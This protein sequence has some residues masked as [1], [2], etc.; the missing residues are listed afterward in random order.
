MTT[1]KGHG[2]S[3]C[4]CL[5]LC[6]FAGGWRKREEE[7]EAKALLLVEASL[8]LPLCSCICV[9]AGCVWLSQD[10]PK[11]AT[12]RNMSQDRKR[13][14]TREN[15]LE[16]YSYTTEEA[17]KGSNGTLHLLYACVTNL[18]RIRMGNPSKTMVKTSFSV[19]NG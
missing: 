13:K 1:C 7:E 15:R 16:K 3:S 10:L 4:C 17:K 11:S 19:L 9:A 8:G 12:L 14:R 18:V 2:S 6:L 5:F